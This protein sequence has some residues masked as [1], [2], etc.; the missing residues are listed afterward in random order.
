MTG[1]PGWID[2]ESYNIEAKTVG[3]VEI[4]RDNFPALM[5]S[6]LVSRFA[7]KFHRETAQAAAYS[8]EVTKSGA[9]LKASAA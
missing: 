2:S 6:L 3:A 8:L 4:T 1:A 9:R 7:F 5:E